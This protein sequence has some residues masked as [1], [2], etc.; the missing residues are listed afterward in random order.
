MY[1]NIHQIINIEKAV[2]IFPPLSDPGFFWLV[3]SEEHLFLIYWVSSNEEAH[4]CH[5]SLKS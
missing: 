5:A 1:P 2:Q 4:H 3:T